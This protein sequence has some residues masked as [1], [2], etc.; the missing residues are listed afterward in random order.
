MLLIPLCML[1]NSQ[2]MPP[3]W[4]KGNASALRSA[5][6]TASRSPMPLATA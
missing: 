4:V 5:A 2:V 3:M 6:V 1:V